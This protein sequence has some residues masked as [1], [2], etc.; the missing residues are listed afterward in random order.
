MRIL[1]IWVKK[2]NKIMSLNVQGSILCFSARSFEYQIFNKDL[3]S[4]FLVQV[5]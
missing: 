5:L 1:V 3:K 2:E 4:Y